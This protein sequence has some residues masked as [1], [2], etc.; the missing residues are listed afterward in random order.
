M[1]APQKRA[2]RDSDAKTAKRDVF[3]P[4]KPEKYVRIVF[5]ALHDYA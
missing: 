2:Q 3:P 5:M 1:Y 4:G